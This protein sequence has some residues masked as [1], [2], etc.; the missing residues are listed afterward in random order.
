MD[1][2][3]IRDK[4][5]EQRALYQQS[6]QAA[7]AEAEKIQATLNS[8]TKEEKSVLQDVLGDDYFDLTTIDLER[9]KSDETYLQTCQ[10]ALDLAIRKLHQHLEAA[11]SV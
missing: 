2:S 1:T 7:A 5:L 4:I 11:I 9:I 6:K 8:I 3:K 10:T